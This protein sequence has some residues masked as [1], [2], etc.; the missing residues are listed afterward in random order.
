MSDSHEI[1]IVKQELEQMHAKTCLLMTQFIGGHQCP[2]IAHMIVS[3]LQW[4]VSHTRNSGSPNS[5]AMYLQL[6]E[7]WQQAT[8]LLLERRATRHKKQDSVILH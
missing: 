8:Q 4:L 7:H 3:H 5:L 1:S 2:K 6:L